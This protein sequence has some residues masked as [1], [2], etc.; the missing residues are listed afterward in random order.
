MIFNYFH[1]FIW[2]C[3][4]LLPN[5]E[6]FYVFLR[7]LVILQ[8]FILMVL[9]HL[10][11]G[12]S[13]FFINRRSVFSYGPR[14]FLR[15]P[16]DFVLDSWVFDSLILTDKLFTKALWRFATCWLVNYSLWGKSHHQYFEIDDCLK[17]TWISFLIAN[18]NLLSC[19]FGSFKFKL[20]LRHCILILY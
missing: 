7:L 12:W 14:V 20:A 18:F 4:I 1:F 17:V 9:K 10:A 13:I 2:Y 3:F 8:L 5:L 16:P 19:E 15:N 11:N 6:F